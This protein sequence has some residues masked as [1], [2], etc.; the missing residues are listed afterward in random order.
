VTLQPRFSAARRRRGAEAG[1]PAAPDPRLRTAFAAVWLLG[2]VK[3]LAEGGAA[4]V[5]YGDLVTA[6]AP[7][8][9]SESPPAGPASPAQAVLRELASC[10]RSAVLGCRSSQPLSAIGLHLRRGDGTV[11]LLGN[12]TGA[13]LTLSVRGMPPGAYVARDVVS[14]PGDSSPVLRLDRD[15][16]FGWELRPHA[17]AAFSLAGQGSPA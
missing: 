16:G 13:P 9:G 2:S 4:S 3:Y 5:T 7:G 15:G 8:P 11:L 1:P 10:T 6:A 12:L 17:I 14:G